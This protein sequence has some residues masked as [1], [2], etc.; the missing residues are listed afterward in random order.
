MK[1]LFTGLAG[2]IFGFLVIYLLWCLIAQR[3][4]SLDL[5]RVFYYMALAFPFC[6][7]LEVGFGNLHHYLFNEYLWQ[8][9][10]LPVHQ[11]LTSTLNFAIWPLY[12][13]HFY[14]YDVVEKQFTFSKFWKNVFFITKLAISGPLLEFILNMVCRFSFERYYFY[15]FPDD[16]FH[17]TSIQVIPY[18][19]IASYAFAVAVKYMDKH[20][21]KTY[22]PLVSYFIGLVFLFSGS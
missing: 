3:F 7:I 2:F 6:L 1:I 8:Y 18:Y 17:Y 14:L 11:G 22:I 12:G 5:R 13:L 16:L 19:F 10:V 15:Y 9:R 21:E 4:I 20:M